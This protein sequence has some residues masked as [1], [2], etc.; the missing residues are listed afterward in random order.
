MTAVIIAIVA[1]V[2]AGAIVA[3]LMWGV[4]YRKRGEAQLEEARRSS[5]RIVADAN[6]QAEARVKEAD[7]EAKEKLL[8]MRSDFDRKVQQ[9]NDE[10]KNSERRLQ[11]KE[12]NLDKKTQQ[13]DSRMAEV[14]KRDRAIDSREK[15]IT[16]RE[17]ELNALVEEQRHRIEQ[18]AGL[19]AE[20]AK[21]ELIRGIE[22]EAKIDAANII[23][24]I[25]TEANELGN[26]RARKILGMAIQRMASDYVAE[27]TVSVVDLPSEDM[28]GRII[29]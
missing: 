14:E 28:K 13:M 27:N 19:S 15:Q 12:E 25:E 23:K 6:K 1:G 2:I 9:R 29:G 26:Q 4:V 3:A 7:L 8:Q 24:R 10:L 21:R 11:Q 18:V 16:A 20:E 22:N 5:D 17:D